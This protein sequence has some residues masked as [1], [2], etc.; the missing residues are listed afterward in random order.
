MSL[1][2]PT[3]IIPSTFA[4]IGNSTVSET[5]DVNIQWQKNGTSSLSYFEIDVF[6]NNTEPSLV[7]TTR[8]ISAASAL[9]NVTGVDSKG[10][11]IP[12]VYK[13]T[14][15]AWNS[16]GVVSNGNSYKM[17]IIQLGGNI[18]VRRAAK[19]NGIAL[20]AGNMY[21]VYNNVNGKYYIFTSPLT[22][23]AN[24]NLAVDIIDNYLVFNYDSTRTNQ[25]QLKYT[26][27]SISSSANGNTVINST[28]TSATVP[29]IVFPNYS[30]VF[31]VMAKPTISFAPVP[32]EITAVSYD[33]LSIYSSSTG[34]K[35]SRWILT[36]ADGTVVDDTGEINANNSTYS[37]AG[38]VND[39]NY[40]ITRICEDNYGVQATDSASFHISY[41]ENTDAPLPISVCVG[42]ADGA[43]NIEWSTAT[44]IPG[45]ISSGSAAINF[46]YINLTSGKTVT[47]NTVNG[48]P[49]N[50]TAPFEVA[51]RGEIV[52][53]SAGSIYN[54][55]N[56]NGNT[57]I[58]IDNNQLWYL[59]PDTILN[60]TYITLHTDAKYM[61]VL[62]RDI[63]IAIWYYDSAGRW[64]NDY[65]TIKYFDTHLPSTITSLQI[66]GVQKCDWLCVT[67]N[68]R[69][70]F[71]YTA[72]VQ[73]KP[74]W[75]KDMLF[76]AD[77]NDDLQAGFHLENVAN[78]YIYRENIDKGIIQGQKILTSLLS[79]CPT[80]SGTSQFSAIVSTSYYVKRR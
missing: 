60:L 36:K 11:P 13:L 54:L 22:V 77:F 52:L 67:A 15:T 75:D 26:A 61:T 46:S 10:N 53:P 23:S 3:N 18:T 2:Q 31:Y 32:P 78:C 29:E 59:T 16:W 49:M 6:T 12:V 79:V 68:D 37:Y 62:L 25:T 4:P 51:W 17:R 65:M 58:Y 39:T 1:F 38:F 14:G 48:S 20:T 27:A 44:D 72:G 64:I 7:A 70:S 80:N 69:Q 40:V 30:T 63:G 45:T 47:W 34:L 19:S 35:W 9:D 21:A 33:F 41:I 76:Y 55:L 42:P 28:T 43:A 50:F 8:C 73:Q 74:A 57:G 5:D 66:A 56:I 71:I 24:T